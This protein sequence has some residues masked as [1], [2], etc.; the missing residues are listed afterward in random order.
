MVGSDQHRRDV[1]SRIRSA[2]HGCTQELSQINSAYDALP[3]AYF[4]QSHLSNE[5]LCER[6]LE[7]LR[8][9]DAKVVECAP[10]ELPA[11]IAG[12]LLV[13][14]KRTFV[15]PQG[16]PSE[17]MGSEFTWKVDNQL[18]TEEIEQADGALTGAFCGIA[19]SG[20]IVLHHSETEGR[21]L[22]SLLP[23]WHF[24]VVYAS[25]LVEMLPEY[26][27]R[28]NVPPGLAT[29]I[30]GPSATADIE[31]TRIKGVHGPR[32][33]VVVLVRDV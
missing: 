28:C 17:W 6:M 5:M 15:A 21:R 8:E 11:A 19:D 33:L 29:F 22:I 4:R 30:S 31:M 12:Q 13:S 14:G 25:Q 24:C 3:R 9:Y 7:R 16:V 32:F 1:L 18:T 26:F 10:T 27:G 2:T 20:T 23:D